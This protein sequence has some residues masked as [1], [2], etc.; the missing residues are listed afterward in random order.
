MIARLAFLHDAD[1]RFFALL[2]S[3]S[4]DPA[5]RVTPLTVT[6]YDHENTFLKLAATAGLPHEV[7][8]DMI[9]TVLLA[10][11]LRACRRP[12]LS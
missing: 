6:S 2:E 8:V 11:T 5:L 4:D 1:D 9:T 7:T 10:C 12:G 3:I